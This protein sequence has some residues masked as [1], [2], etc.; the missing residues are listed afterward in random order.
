MMGK[1]IKF[2]LAFY[3]ACVTFFSLFGDVE[4]LSDLSKNLYYLSNSL[5]IMSL[6]FILTK[7]ALLKAYE[8]PFLITKSELWITT[9]LLWTVGLYNTL[10]SVF[11][12]SCLLWLDKYKTMIDNYIFS[13]LGII[14]IFI[15]VM[16]FSYTNKNGRL[17]KR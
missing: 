13:G 2:I 8:L 12:I 3:I 14:T 4:K 9:V 15:L 5:L 11:N 7:K 16:I 6:A 1:M 17:D 10:L